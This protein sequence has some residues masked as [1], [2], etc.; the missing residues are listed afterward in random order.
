LNKEADRALFLY[1]RLFHASSI[2]QSK[3]LEFIGPRH[4][5]IGKP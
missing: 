1:T 2:D 3:T 5:F 4:V